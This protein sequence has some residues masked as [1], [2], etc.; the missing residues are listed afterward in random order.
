MKS[1]G[2]GALGALALVG[3]YALVMGVILWRSHTRTGKPYGITE[4]AFPTPGER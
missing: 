2:L 3:A 1:V 4:P